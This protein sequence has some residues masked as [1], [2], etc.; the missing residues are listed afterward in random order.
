MPTPLRLAGL[1]P[2]GA[3][4]GFRGLSWRPTARKSKRIKL[5]L[6]KKQVFQVRTVCGN[7]GCFGK[8]WPVTKPKSYLFNWFVVRVIALSRNAH[9]QPQAIMKYIPCCCMCFKSDICFCSSLKSI[10]I[11]IKLSEIWYSISPIFT[12]LVFF[13]ILGWLLG[14]EIPSP[15]SSKFFLKNT[16]LYLVPS[17]Y[18][19]SHLRNIINTQL[20]RILFQSPLSQ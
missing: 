9:C 18:N 13:S 14:Y 19:N 5:Q 20:N 8:W 7:G 12:L 4:R 17:Y 15:Q 2:G 6:Q 11:L 10:S 1:K 3:F 16:S